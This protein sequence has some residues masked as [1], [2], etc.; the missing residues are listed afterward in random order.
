MFFN[1]A[2]NAMQE[3]I[4][5]LH[6]ELAESR[7]EAAFY[8]EAAAVSMNEG[9][10]VLDSGKNIVFANTKAREHEAQFNLLKMELMKNQPMIALEGCSAK[11]ERRNFSV[12]EESYTAYT[13]QKTD[14]RSGQ[15]S[16]L[17][18]M[19]Q[20]SITMAFKETQKTFA[21]LLENLRSM[22]NDSII[23][24]KESTEGLVLIKRSANDMEVLA[25]HMSDAVQSTHSLSDR[26][27]EIAS[28]ITLIEDIADQTNLLAL[29]AAIEAARAGVHG[30]G[31]AVVADEVRNL[32]EKTQKATKDIAIVVQSMQQETNEIQSN[33][34]DISNIVTDTKE[35][36]DQLAGK[37]SNFQRNANRASFE[38]EYISD[39]IFGALAKIDHVVYKN[40][41]YA[42]IF[43]EPNE[44]KSV[45]HHDCRLGNWYE[46]GIGKEEFSQ[47]KSYPKLEAPHAIVHTQANLLA[48]QCGSDKA[49]CSKAQIEE[50]VDKIEEASKG[51]FMTLDA[52]LEE[53]AKLMMDEA[54]VKLFDTK[55]VK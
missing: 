17:L 2:N 7:K 50:M 22:K 16:R 4:A 9:L 21:T 20:T 24:S 54:K 51:V 15:D 43:G 14:V 12:A 26:S 40:N 1:K 13:L 29:N 49:L 33:T 44:F 19:H 38:V 46:R 30:R 8:K 28:V 39:E 11:V 6:K 32:A 41:L 52:L 31:F 42:M 25:H 35:I 3:E 37:V 48:Q 10:I 45:S 53:K 47:C 55:E 34:G 36:I 5:S 23:T 27:R 18:S